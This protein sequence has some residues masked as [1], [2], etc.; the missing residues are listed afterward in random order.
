MG[1]ASSFGLGLAAYQPQGINFNSTL[2]KQ[3]F[4][5]PTFFPG[6]LSPFSGGGIYVILVS[7]LTW[8]PRLYRPIYFGETENFNQRVTTSHERY[9]DWCREAGL[10]PLYVAQ[11]GMWGSTKAA[12]TMIEAALIDWYKPACNS[13]V[14]NLFTLAGSLETLFQPF[15][16][17]PPPAPLS[18]LSTLAGL[19]PLMPPPWPL[20]PPLTSSAIKPLSTPRPKAV[21]VFTSFDYDHDESLRMLLVG[22]AKHSDSPFEIHDWSV[23]EP[24]SGDWKEKVRL[25]MRWADQVIVICGEHTD[26]ATG[27]DTELRIAREEKIPYFLLAGYKD[28]AYK[29]PLAALPSDDVYKWT[30][31]NLKILI[32][33]G[34]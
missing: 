33:G 8:G 23:K 25:K 5:E 3:F 4:S 16:N 21:R 2:G 7:D 13:A 19:G 12:R 32:H 20:A 22:Q 6:M 15:R 34:R 14:P 1:P 27:V 31:E 10:G 30:W 29:K 17:V 9:M 26:S 24:F 18:S 11:L 28:R